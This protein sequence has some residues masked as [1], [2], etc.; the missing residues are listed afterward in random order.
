[1]ENPLPYR[2]RHD[3]RSTSSILYVGNS[4]FSC[5]NGIG[6]HV[7]RLHPAAK[8]VQRLRSTSI[9]IT[10]GGLGWH[11]VESYFRPD[12]IGSYSFDD[13]NTVVFETHE[14]LF[15]VVVMMDSSQ[16][17]IHPTLKKAF[18][19][20]VRR[21][22]GTVR[23]YGAEPVFLMSWAYAN[24]PQMTA[25]LAAA[26]AAAGRDNDAAVIPVGLA[27]E[28]A[29]QISDINLYMSDKAHPS[30][31]GTYLAAATLYAA[32]F[33]RSPVGLNYDADLE[34]PAAALLQAVAWETVR[35]YAQS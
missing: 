7:S 33:A 11:D 15:D 25:Q 3:T 31:A 1:M 21:H 19:E 2:S 16:G 26:Y 29:S 27:F 12:A 6:W 4:F 5:N 17:P 28:R 34:S 8:P 24:V 20:A 14:R 35:D 9:T 18:H 23:R 22:C 13:N 30:P 10:G 32:L